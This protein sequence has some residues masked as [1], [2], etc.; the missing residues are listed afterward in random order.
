MPY[1]R[2]EPPPQRGRAVPCYS[3]VP[4]PD[5][6]L[7]IDVR[8]FGAVGDGVTL[9]HAAFQRA[10]DKAAARG[11]G[12]V[13]VS[14]G[15]YLCGTMKLSGNVRLHLEAGAEIHGSRDQADY[16]VIC[17][18]CVGVHARTCRALFWADE[19]DDI[20]ITGYG[21]IHGGGDSPLPG[22][23]YARQRF[24]PAVFLFRGCKG[25]R[26]TDL[27]IKDSR[28]WTVHLLRCTDVR[29]HGLTISN[30]R[31]RMASVGLVIDS[32]NDVLVSDCVIEA[33]DDG[34]AVKSSELDPCENICVTNCILRSSQAAFKIG[35]Q[36][37]GVIRNVMCSN[38]IIDSSHVG[39]GIYMKDGGR[40]E[41]L[42]F[43]DLAITA[44]N[45]FPITVDCTARK[46]AAVTVP[47]QIFDLRLADLTIHGRG[48]CYIQG[49]PEAPIT[50]MVIRD[51]TWAVN[52]FC[53]GRK[54]EKNHGSQTVDPLPGGPDRA[55]EP[56]QFV[57]AHVRGL[58]MGDVAC[59]LGVPLPKADRGLL[60]LDDVHDAAFTDLRGLPPPDGMNALQVHACSD[61]HGLSTALRTGSTVISG[62][63]SGVLKA[64]DPHA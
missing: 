14:P 13:V 44:D 32:S 41:N 35:A 61:L 12:M 24:R 28:Y 17:P 50:R 62:M 60:Y 8:D 45:E 21:S 25:V 18:T 49:H 51:L 33:G 20:S 53:D 6:V 46:D 26:M 48:R 43:C 55:K 22:P 59:H 38:C 39:I 15:R 36:S 10:I 16:E 2:S 5:A 57:F 54:A 58:R 9:D 1:N 11:G 64:F 37:V 7:L 52:G 34:V 3:E 23:E 4:M 27:L 63:E 30:H 29:I 40:F 56:Y 47:G 42:S 19:E 31:Q